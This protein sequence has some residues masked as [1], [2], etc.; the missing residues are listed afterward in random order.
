[1]DYIENKTYDE[2]EPG[3][4]STLSRTLTKRDIQ[5]FAYMSGDINPAHLDEEYAHSSMF[6]ELIAHGMWG[7]SLISTVIGTQLPGPGAI[8]L[9]QSLKF[10]KPVG[11]GDTINVTVTVK[12]KR[13]KNRVLLSCTCTD[14][15]DD[16]VISGEALVIAPNKKIKRKR[17]QLPEI[18]FTDIDNANKN[19]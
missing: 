13:N 7:G 8:Y 11:I 14:Q 18:E 19:S 3:D 16:T 4:S 9:E 15:D 6:R 2:I 10:T 1:M 12:E 17:V 5:L